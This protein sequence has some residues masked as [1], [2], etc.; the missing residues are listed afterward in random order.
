MF[1]PV[2]NIGTVMELQGSVCSIRVYINKS[3]IFLSNSQ[4]LLS[5]LSPPYFH[6]HQVVPMLLLI[7]TMCIGSETYWNSCWTFITRDTFNSYCPR[8]TWFTPHTLQQIIS[9]F[10][11]LKY[12][13]Y[14]QAE[15]FLKNCHRNIH[16]IHYAKIDCQDNMSTFIINIFGICS[17][18]FTTVIIVTYLKTFWTLW[19]SV[20]NF[21]GRTYHTTSPSLS[22]Q[23]IYLL[24]CCSVCVN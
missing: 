11:Y 10:C 19:A 9:I 1:L 16:V 23:K 6:L 7:T 14:T 2:S 15:N 4:V 20:T 18:N 13:L 22:L 5:L 21:S 12:F 24:G 8:Q 3:C 17:P